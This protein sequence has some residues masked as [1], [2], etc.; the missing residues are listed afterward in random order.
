MS[1]STGERT[2]EE[3]NSQ[4]FTN[5]YGDIVCHPTTIVEAKTENQLP[6]DHE[7]QTPLSIAVR[8][9]GSRH[10]ITAV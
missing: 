1:K 3:T 10:S 2:M 8:P 5:W 9:S 4:A 7:G 6:R